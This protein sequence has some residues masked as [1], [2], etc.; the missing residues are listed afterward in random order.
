MRPSNKMLRGLAL[1][2]A[3]VLLASCSQYLDR[4]ETVS[5]NAGDAIAADRVTMMVDPWPRVSAQRN[6]RF[7]GER[8][9]SAV[10][11]YRTNRVIGPKVDGTSAAYEAQ[12]APSAPSE[13][14]GPKPVGPTIT[15]TN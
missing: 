14:G 6:I 11:R 8:M 10:A 5:L 9:Q 7:N 1:T 15:N 3:M 13:G 2:G 12:Q 4:R